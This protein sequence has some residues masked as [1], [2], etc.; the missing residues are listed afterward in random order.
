M[1]QTTT[2]EKKT[3]EVRVVKAAKHHTAYDFQQRYDAIKSLPALSLLV[4]GL[5]NF[6]FSFA[7]KNSYQAYT[8]LRVVEADPVNCGVPGA[9]A[10]AFYSIFL[11][12]GSGSLLLG[13]FGLAFFIKIVHLLSVLI[14]PVTIVACKK[15]WHKKPRDFAHYTDEFDFTVSLADIPVC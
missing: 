2:F 14:C 10:L 8:Q 15:N 4:L 9:N 13:I 3:G 7:F 5:I 11:V 12:L 6:G 1:L